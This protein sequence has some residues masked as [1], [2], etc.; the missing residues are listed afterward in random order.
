M[1]RSAL[2]YSGSHAD[3]ALYGLGNPTGSEAWIASY[4]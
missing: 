4:D 3:Q 2:K 1:E